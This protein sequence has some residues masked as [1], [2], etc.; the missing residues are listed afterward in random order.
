MQMYCVCVAP[1]QSSTRVAHR[2]VQRR[3]DVLACGQE[4]DG[5]VIR[6]G[7]HF[8]RPGLANMYAEGGKLADAGCSYIRAASV[9][10]P[11][12]RV[13]SQ[14]FHVD[15]WCPCK[16]P[17]LSTKKNADKHLEIGGRLEQ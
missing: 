15:S 12:Q 13:Y 5:G 17:A 1:H 11:L 14:H 4:L 16:C 8:M 2:V 7:L 3:C 9:C 10:S 6:V